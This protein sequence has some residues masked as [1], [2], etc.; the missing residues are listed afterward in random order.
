M[1]RS[2]TFEITLRTGARSC[3]N[4]NSEFVKTNESNTFMTSIVPLSLEPVL[5]KVASS[6]GPTGAPA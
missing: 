3:P 2:P 5:V 6:K 1:G 4:A